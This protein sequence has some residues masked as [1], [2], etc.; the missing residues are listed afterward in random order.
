MLEKILENKKDGDILYCYISNSSGKKWAIP[1]KGDIR[2]AFDIYQPTAL[3]GKFVKLVFPFFYKLNFFCKIINAQKTYVNLKP[4]IDRY[5]KNIFGEKCLISYFGGT[6]SVHQKIVLQIIKNK[7]IV[8]YCKI[9]E[10]KDV[11]IL[12]NR[13]C[14]NLNYLKNKGLEGIP[15]VLDR[16]DIGEFYLFCQSSVK[17]KRYKTLTK[18]GDKHFKF[19][20]ELY[21]KTE[22]ELPFFETDYYKMLLNL[23]TNLN[24]ID[25]EKRE[26][27]KKLIDEIITYYNEENVKFC[28]YHGDFTPW[29]TLECESELKVFDFEYSKKTHPP[30][31]DIFHFFLQTEIFVKKNNDVEIILKEFKKFCKLLKKQNIIFEYNRFFVLYL[32]E[33]INLY[34][35]R[36]VER[37]EEIEYLK[38][39]V[40]L[41][42]RLL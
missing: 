16:T 15:Y 38:L 1:I 42:E 31:L 22:M 6:P 8:A 7:K 40:D 13:E 19:L 29:N 26:I 18:I 5:I 33:V 36:G 35:S 41:I 2:Q 14:E 24:R 37:K 4:E 21:S 10:N 3:A 9:A 27:I 20:K 32:I 23:K 12:F 11:G 34:I 25:F 17:E 28:F 30:Y 39:R